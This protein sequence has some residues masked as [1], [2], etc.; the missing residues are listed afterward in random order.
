MK[1][2]VYEPCQSHAVVDR[3][4]LS[5]YRD[6]TQERRC[7]GDRRVAEGRRVPLAGTRRVWRSSGWACHRATVRARE[8]MVLVGVERYGLRCRDLAVARGRSA[9]QT[10]RW[11]DQASPRKKHD[12]RFRKRLEA[13]DAAISGGFP[14]A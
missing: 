13:R 14:G 12:G 4:L 3:N 1:A 11:A 6:Y 10:S 9:D 8:A 5:P 2:V 7:Q